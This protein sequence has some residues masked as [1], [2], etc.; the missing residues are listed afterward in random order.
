M[1]WMG[2]KHLFLLLLKKGVYCNNRISK[3]LGKVFASLQN[4]ETDLELV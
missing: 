1:I 2:E 3:I 4:L